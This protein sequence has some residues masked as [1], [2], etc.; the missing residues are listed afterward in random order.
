[1]WILG[2]S[3]ST[4]RMPSFMAGPYRHLSADPAQPARAM[5]GHGRLGAGAASG[6]PHGGSGVAAGAMLRAERNTLPGS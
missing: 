3:F 5:A 2:S 6:E 4:W 1:M